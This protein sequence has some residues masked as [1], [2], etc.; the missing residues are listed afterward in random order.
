MLD[1]YTFAIKSA[2]Q[3]KVFAEGERVLVRVLGRTGGKYAVSCGGGTFFAESAKTLRKG[4][5]FPALIKYQDG[6]IHLVP[7]T[8][9]AR[10]APQSLEGRGGED[11]IPPALASF[12]SELGVP[13]DA[14]SLTLVQFLRQFGCKFDAAAV[15][16]A[17]NLAAKFPGREKQAAEAAL[18]ALEKGIDADERMIKKILE[19]HDSGESA[20]HNN[21]DE[22][23]ARDSGESAFNGQLDA[24]K[25]GGK[26]S[27][28]EYD[29]ESSPL[30]LFE[31]DTL[32]RSRPG[33]LTLCNHIVS[34]NLHWILLPFEQGAHTRGI[35]RFLLNI[36]QK[37]IEKAEIRAR[38]M[39]K[40]LYFVIHYIKGKPSEVSASDFARELSREL[41]PRGVTLKTRH[42]K[43]AADALFIDSATQLTLDTKA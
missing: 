40:T 27:S 43:K 13:A 35:I 38:V 31:R 14:V 39:D 32:T 41:L 25:G 30:D 24:D 1:R 19:A 10:N 7:Q 11:A 9:S 33:F 4:D 37:T 21:N 26:E 36:A 17:R 29:E 34:S 23:A 12:L 16:R 42:E 22:S 15:S 18:Y 28:L 2:G 5:S 3:G 6:K 8:D 20:A